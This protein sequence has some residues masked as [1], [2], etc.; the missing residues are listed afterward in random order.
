MTVVGERTQTAM[1]DDQAMA[2]LQR[3][4]VDVVLWRDNPPKSKRVRRS[5]TLL[6]EAADTIRRSRTPTNDMAN[7]DDWEPPS[8]WRRGDP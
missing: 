5:L 6:A 7:D 3:V 8:R 4:E 2:L 1:V